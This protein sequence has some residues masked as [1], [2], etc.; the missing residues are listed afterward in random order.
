MSSSWLQQHQQQKQPSYGSLAVPH[1]DLEDQHADHLEPLQED[2]VDDGN[3]SAGGGGFF[4]SNLSERFSLRLSE[5]FTPIYRTVSEVG[6]RFTPLYRTVSEVSQ[7]LIH[8]SFTLSEVA[9]NPDEDRHKHFRSAGTSSIPSEVANLSK[10]T[11][12]GGVMS[13]SGGIALYAN[14][15]SAAISAT[16][17]VLGLGVLFG[18]FCMLSGKACDMSLSATYREC[19][20]RTVGQRGGIWVAIATTLDPLMGL[21]ANSAILSQSLRF[22]L[23]GVG[24]DLAIPQCLLLIALLA[25]LPLCLMKNLDALAP[26]S[27]F[28][29]A[30][31]FTALGCMVVRYLDG[32]YLPGGTFHDQISEEY[33]PSFGNFS[34]PWSFN[35]MPFVCMAFTSFDM[36]Y[37]SP[38]FYTEL[39]DA[40]VPRFAQVCTYSFGIVSFLYLSI[41]VVGYLTFGANSDSYIL[42]NYSPNDSL[43]TVARLSMGFSAMLTYPLNFMGLRDNL[44]DLLGLT[45]KFDT[46]AKLR[47]FIVFL[48]GTCILLACFITDLGLISSVGGG[49]TVALVAFVF[50]AIMFREAVRQHGTKAVGETVQVWVT[51]L[52]MI[53]MVIVGIIGVVSSIVLGA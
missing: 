7:E 16:G 45:D 43:A 50:P 30:S 10:N 24:I 13:L 23:Q 21:F 11:I 35:V 47:V 36:H 9:R 29:M 15:P 52:S 37:N 48:L 46:E 6:E 17:W 1:S 53:T 4:V 18:Y 49:T 44:L 14:S 32:S 12:G 27:V 5:R 25:L 2:E 38:R 51:M 39:K 40:T 3:S 34:N 8:P 28:G 41:A 33:R 31:V 19:W 42:D 20:E 26:F 22:T